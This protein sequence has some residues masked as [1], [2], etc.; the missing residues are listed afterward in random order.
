MSRIVFVWFPA[1]PIDRLRR[2]SPD[3]VPAQHPFAL[4]EGGAHG[5]RIHAANGAAFAAGVRIGQPLADVRAALPDIAIRPAETRRDAKAL[6]HLA[7]WLGR[8]SPVRNTDG[9]DGAWIDIAGAAHLLGGEKALLDDLVGRLSRLGIEAR[10]GLAD[11]YGAAHALAHWQAT[12]RAPAAI[13]AT[14]TKPEGVAA[15]G[16]DPIREALAQLPVAALRL[17]PATTQLLD[18]LGLKRIGLL[19]DLP[20]EAIEHRFRD[21]AGQRGRRLASAEAKA[22]LLRLDQA[23]GHSPEPRTPLAEPPEAIARLVFA[24]PLISHAG[25]M[26]AVDALASDL[27]RQ[28]AGRC[29]AASRFRLSL[30]RS[31]GTAVGITVGTSRPSSDPRHLG[32]LLGE[33]LAA[34]D[35]GFGLDLL[36]LEAD[37]LEIASAE[38]TALG[39]AVTTP[40]DMA[41]ILLDRLVNRLGRE[42][43]VR[44][45]CADSHQPERSERFLAASDATASVAAMSTRDGRAGRPPFLIVPPEPATVM[46]EIPEGAPLRLVWRRIGRRIARAEGP[47]RIAPDWWRHLAS[48]EQDE[49]RVRDYYRLEDES[50]GG[51][52]VFREGR[53]D[54]GASPRWYV[55]GVWT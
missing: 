6:A 42:R 12:V 36:T 35:L 5:L 25:V 45:A 20:R 7:R 16:R 41:G 50:G 33:K 1:W 9:S 21:V 13:A 11:S 17:A 15:A 14:R 52:W 47:E 40:S 19:Y 27:T 28:L 39:G 4:V 43:I 48:T 34:V 2:V 38:Q 30:Y 37:G 24:E 44:L 32:L 46:A 29:R 10:A 54:D 51:Y 55:H 3:L 18:R 23:L 26:S 8:Y 22:V 49:P 53:Y 31:D